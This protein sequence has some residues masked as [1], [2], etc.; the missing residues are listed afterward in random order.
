MDTEK[1]IEALRRRLV[2]V[3]AWDH[4]V[5]GTTVWIFL[6]GAAM[7]V[8]RLLHY[9]LTPAFVASLPLVPI[10]LAAAAILAVRRSPTKEAVAALLDAH[11][12]QGGLVMA[13]EAGLARQ[14]PEASLPPMAVQWQG[15]QPLLVLLAA[16]SFLL[17]AL[18]VPLERMGAGADLPL[19][20]E[21]MVEQLEE[22]IDLLKEIELIEEEQAQEWKT[23]MHALQQESSGT[24][25]VATWE[26]LDQLEKRIEDQAAIEVATRRQ[27]VQKRE[28]LVAALK[29]ALQAY[30]ENRETADAAM[31]ELS[32]LLQKAAEDNPNLKALLESL[33]E[34]GA[35]PLAAGGMLDQKTAQMLAERLSQMTEEDLMRM[36]QLMQQGL[37]QAAAGSPRPG[38]MESLKRF[39]EENPECS[40]LVACAGLSPSPGNGGVSRGPGTA[41]ISWLNETSEEGVDFKEETLTA[42]QTD[43]LKESLLVGESL[44]AP[45]VDSEAA[46]STGGALTGSQANDS[47]AATYQV[48]PRHRDAVNRFFNREEGN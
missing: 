20:I 13:S 21:A 12:T 22:R 24:D 7:L 6:L 11:F 43:S 29:A 15:R 35:Q 1:Q 41:P 3:A 30:E 44:G 34:A 37:G 47:A 45:E 26:A 10:L 25:P 48:L 2:A 46:G 36:Q 4:A 17:A 38:D 16:I 9:R 18:W 39:L 27:E 31:K 5:R 40:N 33:A 14:W 19:E 42:S 32:T 28:E 8:C 23:L